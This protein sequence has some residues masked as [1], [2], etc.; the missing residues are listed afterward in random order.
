[1]T[2][3][4]KEITRLLDEETEQSERTRDEPMTAGGRRHANRTKLFAV[5]FTEDEYA[6]VQR[7][8]ERAGVPAATLVR[9]YVLAGVAGDR[10]DSVQQ[11]VESL[12]RDV[13]RLRRQL[14][15]A[16]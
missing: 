3:S 4:R 11:T 15:E 10:G 12:D 16:S 1:M 6:E 8:A 2:R 5:R 13:Q 14:S 7:A 9:D